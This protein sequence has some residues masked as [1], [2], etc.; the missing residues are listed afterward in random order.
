MSLYSILKEKIPEGK[1]VSNNTEFLMR[2]PFC[3]D[4]RKDR[5]DAHFYIS[6]RD[7]KPHFYNCF[8]CGTKGVLNRKILRY[9]GIY[10]EESV[11]LVSK[12]ID[13]KFTPLKYRKVYIPKAREQWEIDKLYYIANRLGSKKFGLYLDKLR[14]VTNLRKLIEYNRIPVKSMK[15]IEFLDQNYIGFLLEDKGSVLLRKITDSEYGNRWFRYNLF[16]SD[17]SS[18][19]IDCKLEFPI[20]PKI[21]IAEGILDIISIYSNSTD[22]ERSEGVYFA[23][24]NRNYIGNIKNIIQRIPSTHLEFHVFID[25]DIDLKYL[26]NTIIKEFSVLK[27]FLS[28]LIHK[29]EFEGEKDYGVPVSKIKDTIYKII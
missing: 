21:Y 24:G 5:S 26:I 8:L 11:R 4:S 1:L 3:G 15:Q 25:N 19:V 7:D 17:C 23:I 22:K 13:I 6:L 20:E 2:C 29:N 9:M 28:I 14:I 18:Y 16:D 12:K 10:D 27:S